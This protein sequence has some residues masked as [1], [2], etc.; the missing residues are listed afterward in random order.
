[1][2]S[3]IADVATDAAPRYAKQ[4]ASHLGRR[5]PVEE[6]SDGG[7]KLTIGSGE[8]VLEPQ[9]D[10]LVLRATAPDQESLGVV[11]DVLGRHLE[12][13]GQRVGLTV[14]WTSA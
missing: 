4:L 12:R 1:M 13:F 9:A 14:T 6:L 10:R 3:S 8:G 5:A 2:F 11:Q 7:Y